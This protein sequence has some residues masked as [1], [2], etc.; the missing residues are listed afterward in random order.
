MTEYAKLSRV[1]DRLATVSDLVTTAKLITDTRYIDLTAVSP[2]PLVG[3]YYTEADGFSESIPAAA[4]TG[5]VMDSTD[6]YLGRLTNQ[7]RGRMFALS[8]KDIGPITL[9]DEN[10]GR[11][12]AYLMLTTANLVSLDHRESVFIF[13][14]LETSTA[15]GAGRAAEILA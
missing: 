1:N 9:S 6:F 10:R 11:L 5:R 15:I 12:L 14:A 13:N 2:L 7:E 8:Q 3:W 4:T